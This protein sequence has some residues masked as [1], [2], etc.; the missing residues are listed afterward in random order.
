MV[1]NV[2]FGLHKELKELVSMLGYLILRSNNSESNVF[3]LIIAEMI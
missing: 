3:S 1:I 2:A